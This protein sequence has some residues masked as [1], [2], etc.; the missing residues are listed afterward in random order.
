[1]GPKAQRKSPNRSKSPKKGE[2]LDMGF[3][4]TLLSDVNKYF[5]NKVF[6]QTDS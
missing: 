4:T 1:M 3:V 6:L 2:T 5:S